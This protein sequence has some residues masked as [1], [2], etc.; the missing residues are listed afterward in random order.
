MEKQRLA[1]TYAY[2][3]PELVDMEAA[4]IARALKISVAWLIGE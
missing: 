4:A 1:A 2:K 3:T